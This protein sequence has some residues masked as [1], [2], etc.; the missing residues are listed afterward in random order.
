MKSS[1]LRGRRSGAPPFATEPW[2]VKH[3]KKHRVVTKLCSCNQVKDMF[4]S[5]LPCFLPVTILELVCTQQRCI[6]S[7]VL[8]T[9]HLKLLQITLILKTCQ[10]NEPKPLDRFL[11]ILR[12]LLQVSQIQNQFQDFLESERSLR[13]STG[14]QHLVNPHIFYKQKSEQQKLQ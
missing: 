6:D 9:Y 7:A 8:K 14:S 10:V 2:G 1:K 11:S 3:C 4:M 13:S 12:S 5:F